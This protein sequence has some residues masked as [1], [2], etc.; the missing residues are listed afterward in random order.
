MSD[1]RDVGSM[2]QDTATWLDEVLSSCI[3]WHD[4]GSRVS[5]N[6]PPTD[7]DRD[8]LCLVI[9]A[10]AF[11]AAATGFHW[12]GSVVGPLSEA[13]ERN[14]FVSLRSRDVNLIVTSDARFAARFL[15]ATRLATQLNLLNKND[16]VALFQAVLYGKG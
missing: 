7:T 5:C 13:I 12:G 9:D 8:I 3:E 11:A 15:V 14:V 16:R 2:T 1:E 6:P 10:D 4:V